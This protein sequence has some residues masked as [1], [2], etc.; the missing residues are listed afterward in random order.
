M[1]ARL[2]TLTA[3]LL[4]LAIL[5][6][7][8]QTSPHWE[9]NF[10]TSLRASLAAQVAD[11]AAARNPNPNPV[12][13][14]DGRAAAAAAHRYEASFSRPADQQSMISGPGK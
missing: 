6:G 11:P 8:A 12:I 5:S 9:K 4:A 1:N 3:G 7:C 13:G 2:T 14:L 10:G